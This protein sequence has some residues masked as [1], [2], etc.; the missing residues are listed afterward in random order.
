MSIDRDSL[1][2]AL[3]RLSSA[4]DNDALAAAR[5]VAQL[6]DK[7]DLDWEDIVPKGL[8]AAA[9]STPKMDLSSDDASIVKAIDAILARPGLNEGT[10]DDLAD[11]KADLERGELEADDRTY[12]L[13][14]YGRLSG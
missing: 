4:E 12:I 13:G 3:E 8:G 11:L 5:E 10:A 14:L 9:V 7:G 2:D 6:A 1:V